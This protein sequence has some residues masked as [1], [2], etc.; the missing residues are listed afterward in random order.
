MSTLARGGGASPVSL[1]VGAGN[2]VGGRSRGGEAAQVRRGE[3]GLGPLGQ[4]RKKSNFNSHLEVEQV[5]E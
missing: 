4:L 3:A 5:R 1:A 2:R